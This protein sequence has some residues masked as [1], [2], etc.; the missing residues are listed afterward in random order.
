MMDYFSLNK[1]RKSSGLVLSLGY[2]RIQQN[3]ILSLVQLLFFYPFTIK[4]HT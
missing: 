1:I 3:G 4:T 2:D